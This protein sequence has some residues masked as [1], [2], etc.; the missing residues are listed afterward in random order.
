MPVGG[1]NNQG[2]PHAPSEQTLAMAGAF[3]TRSTHQH[4]PPVPYTVYPNNQTQIRPPV[5]IPVASSGHDRRQRRSTSTAHRRRLGSLRTELVSAFP[6]R[7]F[8][9]TTIP[10]QHSQM[11]AP[12]SRRHTAL[13]AIQ[14]RSSSTSRLDSAQRRYAVER[15]DSTGA[16]IFRATQND[17]NNLLRTGTYTNVR[18]VFLQRLA[19]PT[20]RFQPEH[21]PVHHRRLDAVRSHRVQWR[22]QV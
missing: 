22:R 9:R 6:S 10:S 19:D 11:Q 12:D 21:Q 2:N 13:K 20:Q 18:T 8:R 14:P 15:Y 5:A 17:D 1:R 7:C 16:R 3:S 4:Q